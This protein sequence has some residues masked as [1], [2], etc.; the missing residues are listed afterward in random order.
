[1][2]LRANIGLYL[3]EKSVYFR[4][5]GVL[6]GDVPI[7]GLKIFCNLNTYVGATYL[8][9]GRVKYSCSCARPEGVW[10]VEVQFHVFLTLELVVS[11]KLRP[12]Y[13]GTRG[14]IHHSLVFSLIGRAGRN[15]SPVM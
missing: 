1:M 13:P 5:S 15:Q 11:Y 14:I 8:S 3:T 12:F 10:E 6:E 2:V 4:N 7:T 9:P